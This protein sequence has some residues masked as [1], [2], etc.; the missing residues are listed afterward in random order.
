[1]EPAGQLMEQRGQVAVRDDR[2][3]DGQQCPVRLAGA[4]RLSVRVSGCYGGDPGRSLI[5][6][7]QVVRR[8]PGFEVASVKNIL[9]FFES[10]RAV[11]GDLA[12]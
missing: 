8:T 11:S 5:K 6:N 9:A 12:S 7:H 3:R 4:R 10:A 1:M 2:F